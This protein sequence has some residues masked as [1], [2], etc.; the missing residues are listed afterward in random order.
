VIL[1]D[2]DRDEDCSFK[3]TERSAE[4][5][6]EIMRVQAKSHLCKWTGTAA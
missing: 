5:R 1:Q 4:L 2:F 6:C 3:G